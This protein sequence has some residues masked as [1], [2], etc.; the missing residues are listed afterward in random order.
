MVLARVSYGNTCYYVLWIVALAAKT[1]PNQTRNF[2]SDFDAVSHRMCA[3]VYRSR[4][5]S[6]NTLI[7][8]ATPQLHRL[9]G[10]CVQ[11]AQVRRRTGEIVSLGGR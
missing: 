2:D 8:S 4:R 5:E 7:I 1:K 6:M 10:R 9:Y 11:T 3:C